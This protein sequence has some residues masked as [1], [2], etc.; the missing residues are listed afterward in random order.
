LIVTENQADTFLHR[1]EVGPLIGGFINQY[2]KWRWTFYV[3]L[4]WAGVQLGLIVFLVPETYHPVL[5]R[6]RA[7][8]LR[9]E[10]GNDAWH[11]PIE[12][13]TRSLPQTLLWSCIRPFQLLGRVDT[14]RKLYLSPADVELPSL[15]TN[16]KNSN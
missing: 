15:R 1:P 2:T 6:Q 5:L 9:K 16:G 12:K 8:Q 7:R 14:R 13:L 11:A 3:L 4:I 10:T